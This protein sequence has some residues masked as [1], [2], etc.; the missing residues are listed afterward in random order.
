ML[1]DW[2]RISSFCRFCR[3][4]VIGLDANK[5]YSFRIRAENQYGV[6][7]PLE[8]DSPITAKFP[9]NVPDAPQRP[10]C[11]DTDLG[12]ATI[13]WLRPAS[14]GGARIQGY[15]LEYRDVTEKD[16]R[17]ANEYLVKDTSYKIHGLITGKEY[18]FRV[19][20]KNVAGFSKP[21][22]TSQRLKLKGACGVPSPPG[23]PQVIKVGKGYVDL[24]WEVPKSDGGSRIT[25]YII[26]KREIGNA[27]WIKCNDYGVIDTTYTAI[28][29]QDGLDY[30]FRVYAVNAVGHSEPSASTKP[31]KISEIEGGVKPEF[32]RKLVSKSAG[33]NRSVTLECEA[34]GKPTPTSRWL[35]NGR[36]VC[37]GGRI[38]MKETNGVFQL[39]M[40]E[41]WE[42]DDGDYTCEAS[43]TFGSVTCTAR[44][45][46]EVS[47]KI[48]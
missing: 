24:T 41:V 34:I 11:T 15:R 23:T 6:S 19:K 39:T 48:S 38:S 25:G 36:E 27:F 16:W 2:V 43:N 33:L 46:S 37:V 29:L 42:N 5:K 47:N 4:D 30:E 8:L 7:D 1:Q 45:K 31:V 22:P 14:D 28:N 32:I 3:H 20:A 12:S 40:D 17:I 26:E 35:K 10:Q 9:F 18:E 44:L 21:S 13:T